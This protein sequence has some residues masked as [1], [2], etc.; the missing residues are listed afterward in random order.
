[1]MV[2][3]EEY[4]KAKC[5]VGKEFPSKES[6]WRAVLFAPWAHSKN[7]EYGRKK[8]PQKERGVFASLAKKL[9][10]NQSE[11]QSEG[12]MAVAGDAGWGS[13]DP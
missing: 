3:G 2:Q 8:W 5:N 10:K 13:D 11:G 4:P 1:M 12:D 6:R 7:K 9:S